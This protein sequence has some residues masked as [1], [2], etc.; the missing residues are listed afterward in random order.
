MNKKIGEYFVSL[1]VLS[2][3][4]A[5]KI[6]KVQNEYPDKKFG[7]IAVQLDYLDQ[8]EVEEYLGRITK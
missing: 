8:K 2:F 1:N 7:E 6:L 5:E 4:Q 3:E